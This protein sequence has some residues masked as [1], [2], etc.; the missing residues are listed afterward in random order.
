M[1]HRDAVVIIDLP[2]IV[3]LAE[4]IRLAPAADHV[5]LVIRW[6]RSERQFVQFALDS[7][8]AAGISTVAV[9]LNDVDLKA[10]RRR[11]YRDYH[12]VAYTDKK[13]YRRP[14]AGTRDPAVPAPLLAS[15]AAPPDTSYPDTSY[16]DT[17]FKI[18]GSRPQRGDKHDDSPG[19]VKSD[20]A[21]LYDRYRG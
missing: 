12:T 1:K 14:P 20:I 4:T 7:L 8:R 10:Q 15:V 13:L 17:S 2:P 6:G 18:N 5:A 19:S 16:P 9:I 21:K 3:G 11:G